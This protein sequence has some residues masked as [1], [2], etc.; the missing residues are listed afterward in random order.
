MLTVED[1]AAGMRLDRWLT[2]AVPDLSRARVQVL[3]DEGHVRVA[4]VSPKAAH[5]LRGGEA[6]EIEIPPPPAPWGHSAPRATAVGCSP[7]R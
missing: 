5:R 2:R 7:Y 6:V 4:G 3:I 1:E